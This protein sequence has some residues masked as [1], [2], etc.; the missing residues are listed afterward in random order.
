MSLV[1]GNLGVWVNV[2][3]DDAINYIQ[4]WYLLQITNIHTYI[5]TQ[6]SCAVN[7]H[8]QGRVTLT[9]IFPSVRILACRELDFALHFN[10]LSGLGLAEPCS[11]RRCCF[12][13]RE[14]H[15]STGLRAGRAFRWVFWQQEQAQ[16]LGG[17]IFSL[18]FVHLFSELILYFVIV[19]CFSSILDRSPHWNSFIYTERS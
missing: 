5:H 10:L 4:L 7:F 9:V 14:G 3:T 12:H 1:C 13:G 17:T 19:C 16:Y 15:P 8:S 11:F 18:F 2:F 6:Y